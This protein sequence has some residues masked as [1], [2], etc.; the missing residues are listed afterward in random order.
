M[1]EKIDKWILVNVEM[2]FV[3]S[4]YVCEVAQADKGN[5]PVWTVMF[6]LTTL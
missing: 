3:T 2:Q 5:S 4:F 1:N 6:S